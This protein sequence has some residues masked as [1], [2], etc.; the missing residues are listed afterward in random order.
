MGK[1][2]SLILSDD[3]ARSRRVNVKRL[4]RKVEMEWGGGLSQEER[5]DRPGRQGQLPPVLHRF[6]L[7]TRN[8]RSRT[9]FHRPRLRDSER[10][11]ETRAGS[12]QLKS[13]GT[14]QVI[15][16]EED[17]RPV[18]VREIFHQFVQGTVG[19]FP[20]SLQDLIGSLSRGL[21]GL[22]FLAEGRRSKLHLSAGDL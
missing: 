12:Y 17:V 18:E 1:S 3:E 14:A 16:F 9:L 4:R 21:H 10:G 5:R 22:L 8:S 7:L 20:Y 13:A 15:D 2:S 6:H 19:M 11:D